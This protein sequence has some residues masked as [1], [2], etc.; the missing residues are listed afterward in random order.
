VTTLYTRRWTKILT[1]LSDKNLEVCSWAREDSYLVDNYTLP[2]YIEREPV[3]AR[4]VRRM[5]LLA[6][7]DRVSKIQADVVVAMRKPVPRC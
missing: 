5:L 7:A 6:F 4:L 1:D 2:K 3:L